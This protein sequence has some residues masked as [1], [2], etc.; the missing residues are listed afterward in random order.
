MIVTPRLAMIGRGSRGMMC[1]V[2]PDS[3]MPLRCMT[4][5]IGAPCSDAA[6]NPLSACPDTH[7]ASPQWQTTNAAS[8]LRAFIPSARPVAT[9]II[10]PSRPEP[11]G[12]PPG[13]QDTC[14][15]ISRLRRKLSMTR[16]RGR[17]PS[18]DRAE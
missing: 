3:W 14:P 16:S 8:P 12:V 10:T 15:A 4:K 13:T 18:A 11:S 2:V 17:N 7:P 1:A 9:G 6:L 5:V